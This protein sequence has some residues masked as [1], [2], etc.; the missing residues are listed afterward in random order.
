MW[1]LRVV[2]FQQDKDDR[3]FGIKIV[4]GILNIWKDMVQQCG[5][6]TPANT[7]KYY[8]RAQIKSTFLIQ[9]NNTTNFSELLQLEA[10]DNFENIS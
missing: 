6:K 2:S 7:G 4:K 5:G 8:I 3:D 10:R 9:F 1:V